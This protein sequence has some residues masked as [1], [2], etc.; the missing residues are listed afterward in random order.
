MNQITQTINLAS[1]HTFQLPAEAQQLIV[2]NDASQLPTI[3][4]NAYILGAGS[5]TLFIEDFTLP[6]VRIEL[7]GIDIKECD[8]AWQITVAAG[9]DWHQFVCKLLDQGINGLE[10]LALIPG[11]VGAAPVQNIGAYGR[12]VSQFV[13]SVLAWDRATQKTTRLDNKDCDFGYRDS[14]FKKNPS[15]WVICDVVFRIPKKWQPEVSYG[16]LKSLQAPITAKAIFEKVI[17]VRSAK[18]PDPKVIP[19]AGSFF[20]NPIIDTEEFSRIIQDHPDMPHFKTLEGQVKIAAGWLIDKL[21]LKGLT[22]GGAAVHEQQALVLVNKNNAKGS[23]VLTLARH[24]RTV[25]KNE[26]GIQLEAEVRLLGELG[27]VEL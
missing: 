10:N 11:T 22:I 26:F 20:K 25:V 27:L 16:E 18:L 17:E 9:E 1:L 19:N 24:I 15:R 8:D 13:T 12:E 6:L 14:I 3:P 5:N 23:D 4:A 7:K 2:L 21:K